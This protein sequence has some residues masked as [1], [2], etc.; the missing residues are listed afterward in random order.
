MANGNIISFLESNP[1]HDRLRAVGTFPVISSNPM[2]ISSQVIEIAQGIEYLHSQDPQ[3]V[4]ADLRGVCPSEISSTMC[5]DGPRQANILVTDEHRCV[6]AD[7][8]LSRVIETQAPASSSMT[9]QGSLR[10]L[11]PEM[12]D[13]RLFDTAHFPARDIYSFGCTIIEVLLFS[14]YPLSFVALTNQSDLYGRAAFLAD[15]I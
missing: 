11:P 12:M 3:I 9:L 8:G 15:S 10:W 1:N 13:M 6:L 7:F 4:H 14:V 5:T 2:T